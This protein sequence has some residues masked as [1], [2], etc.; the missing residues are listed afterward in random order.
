MK[1]EQITL[2]NFRQYYGNNSINLLPEEDRNIILIG[3]KNGYGKTNLLVGL[4]WC[5]YGEKLEKIDENFKKE[6]RK[7]GSYPKFLKHSLNQFAKNDGTSQ[8]YVEIIINDI[9]L[10]SLENVPQSKAYQCRIK[11]A[12]DIEQMVDDFEIE[13]LGL[14]NQMFKDEV[15]KVN[16]INDYVIPFEAAKFVFFDAEQIASMAELSTKEEGSVL[17]DALGKILGLDLYTNLRDDLKIYSDNLRKQ[18]GSKIIQEQINNCEQTLKVNELQVDSLESEIL[19][20]EKEVTSVRANLN[21]YEAYLRNYSSGN[22]SENQLENLYSG[23]KK[24]VEKLKISQAKFDDFSEIIP[25]AILGGKLEE[26]V[27]HLSDQE[28]INTNKEV[29]LELNEKVTEFIEALF[30]KPD[31]PTNGDISFSQKLFYAQKTEGLFKNIFFDKDASDETDNLIFEHDLNN[32]DK[33][34]IRDTYRILTNQ[35]K[36]SFEQVIGE[37]DSLK[38]DLDEIDK[39]IKRAESDIEDEEIVLYSNK[40]EEADRKLTRILENI[41]AKKNTIKNLQKSNTSTSKQKKELI[42]KI[43]VTQYNLVK[44]KKANDYIDTLEKFERNQKE[45][46]CENLSKTL[47]KELLKLMHKFENNNTGFISDVSIEPLPENDGLKVTLYNEDGEIIR[48]ESLSQG[49]KQIYISSLIKAI[50]SESIQNLPIF[51]DTPLARLDGDHIRKILLYFYPDLSEQVVLLAT[52]NEIPPSRLKLLEHKVA[53]TY[54]LDNN[55]NKTSFKTGYFK[56]L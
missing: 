42:K 40:K 55:N 53:K 11:R 34:F 16:F 28:K 6:V 17:N 18:S 43:E 21:E 13:I 29:E 50:L 36:N 8:F 45:S 20:L 52:N 26:V 19:N 9:E 47:L 2:N 37:F 27:E 1:I 12:F 35:T 4:V 14:K 30:N 48:K 33:N 25:L 10:P 22:F 44:L 39:S 5:L 46:K 31:F 24:L 7:E 32:S 15:D 23:R 54:V 56:A 38:N 3:G 41:G 49:E 51:I